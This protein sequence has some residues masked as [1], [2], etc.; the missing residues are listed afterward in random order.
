MTVSE[1]KESTPPKYAGV[2]L[3]T[4]GDDYQMHNIMK[5]LRG[6]KIIV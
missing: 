3:S 6:V 1:E 4:P 2:F 5:A